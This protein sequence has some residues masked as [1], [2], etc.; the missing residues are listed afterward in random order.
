MALVQRNVQLEYVQGAL[1]IAFGR[2]AF[3]GER[4]TMRWS[5]LI[6]SK[7]SFGRWTSRSEQIYLNVCSCALVRISPT[8]CKAQSYWSSNSAQSFS[9]I[10]PV[11]LEI[12]KRC[13]HLCTCTC[14]PPSSFVK[15]QVNGSLTT[16]QI[17]TQS[18]QPFPI[19][20]K[21]G[22]STRCWLVGFWI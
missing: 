5:K 1:L 4:A 16:N 12:W 3:H 15:R 21:G 13:A 19:Y 8:L 2:N 7:T 20:G 17:S 14:T 10:L 6:T 18:V 11:V 9:V 22:T